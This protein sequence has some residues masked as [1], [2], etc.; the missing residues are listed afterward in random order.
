MFLNSPVKILPLGRFESGSSDIILLLGCPDTV[1]PDKSSCPGSKVHDSPD[2]LSSP[3]E[4]SELGS[5]SSFLSVNWNVNWNPWACDRRHRILALFD[6]RRLFLSPL[7]AFSLRFGR[8][9]EQI[10][11]SLFDLWTL[12]GHFGSS[13]FLPFKILVWWCSRDGSAFAPFLEGVRGCLARRSG[14]STSLL[15][16]IQVS[17]ASQFYSAHWKTSLTFSRSV[18][19][20]NVRI[21][22][23]RRLTS[24]C[25]ILSRAYH[26]QPGNLG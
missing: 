6:Q 20:K 26:D 23:S 2:N 14:L 11:F 9:F 12:R 21:A 17:L 3:D 5:Y 25:F 16:A 8:S 7:V 19:S 24:S 13:Y 10:M 4:Q 1:S 15:I 22:A 18:V